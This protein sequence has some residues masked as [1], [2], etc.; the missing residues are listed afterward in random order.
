[1]CY[2]LIDNNVICKAFEDKQS[3]IIPKFPNDHKIKDLDIKIR[4]FYGV[5]EIF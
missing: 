5:F 3:E 1:M 2:I 4:E